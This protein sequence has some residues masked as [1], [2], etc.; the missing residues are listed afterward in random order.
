MTSRFDLD[1]DA[2]L[3]GWMADG[4]ERAPDT[5]V[6]AAIE[7][8][9]SMAQAWPI[10][11]PRTASVRW[12]AVAAILVATV[13]ALVL[14]TGGTRPSPDPAPSIRAFV[15]PSDSTKPAILDGVWATRATA[16]YLPGGRYELQLGDFAR[17]EGPDG[18]VQWL[19]PVTWSRD[20]MGSVCRRGS[21]ASGRRAS[22]AGPW[23]PATTS[24]SRPSTS[25]VPGG[26][27]RS[28]GVHGHASRWA[29]PRRERTGST[30][31]ASRSASRSRMACRS[32]PR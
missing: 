17:V 28:T 2:V 18:F 8:T 27:Q 26:R 30:S 11:R 6:R 16:G 13:V 1:F 20:A 25:H 15:P 31:S 10:A 9:R 14:V 23:P 4:P 32:A 5:V 29:R 12:L 3:A 7:E 19:R 21:R 22:M 24:D